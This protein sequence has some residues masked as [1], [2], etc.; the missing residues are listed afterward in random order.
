MISMIYFNNRGRPYACGILCILYMYSYKLDTQHKNN[1]PFT[2][3]AVNQ[4]PQIY[5]RE[6]FT[7]CLSWIYVY[8]LEQQKGDDIRKVGRETSR[9]RKRNESTPSA[10]VWFCR[11]IMYT[12]LIT[13][14]ISNNRNSVDLLLQKWL[15]L[16]VTLYK[17]IYS[18][19]CVQVSKLSTHRKK[20]YIFARR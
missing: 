17:Y 12:E 4:G 7:A 3:C 1:I 2:T 13:I 14:I 6:H 20:T 5:T 8:S 9:R 15:S 16:L 10:N 19:A 18:M 11:N